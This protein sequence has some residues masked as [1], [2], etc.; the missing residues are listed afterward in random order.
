MRIEDTDIKMNRAGCGSKSG[1]ALL[2][3]RTA[4]RAG[5]QDRGRSDLNTL[6]EEKSKHL[7]CRCLQWN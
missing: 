3:L 6:P 5:P 4:L 1:G 2:I 7:F